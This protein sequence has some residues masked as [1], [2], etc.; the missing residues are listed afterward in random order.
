MFIAIAIVTLILLIIIHE[1]GHFVAAK[2]LGVKVEEFGLGYPPRLWG[3]KIGETLY[4]LNL[5][6]FGGFVK[7][8]GQEGSIKDPNSFSEKPF[9]K[10]SVIILGG[11]FSFWVVSV[12]LIA[13]VMGIGAPSEISDEQ[14]SG[15]INPKVQ[16]LGIQKDSPA[17]LAE[18]KT[19]DV[20]KEI[21][22]ISV[23]KVSQ[24]QKITQEN[25]G[26]EITLAIQR[27]GEILNVKI[28]PRADSK[29]GEGPIGIAL[30][31]TALI[32]Y[33]WYIAPIKGA[34][35]TIALTWAII[36][37]W[38]M[39]FS[40]LF[41]GQ[42]L[43][44]GA[45]V[46]GVVGIFQLFS[47]VG[48]LGASYF[49][50]FIALIAVNLALINSLPIPAL[51]GGWFMFLVIEKLRGRPLNERIIQRVSAMFFFLLIGLMIWVTIRD[52]VRIF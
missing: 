46:T 31:R 45:E 8:Y 26:R 42:G 5:L 10:K 52:I 19:G 18:L 41:Q 34:E 24:V 6:P 9:W 39:L 3:K 32:K 49:I 47:E 16:I 12:I 23:D 29:E 2:F 21:N 25:R 15:V 20:V 50:H 43:P 22:N 35:G 13:I 1:L 14:V 28:T 36:Q 48:G 4:S 11:V 51:D 37:S 27:G 40:S 33:P 44:P 30:A 17:A 38:I 7:I